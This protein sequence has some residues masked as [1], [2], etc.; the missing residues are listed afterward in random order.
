MADGSPPLAR[1]RA[2]AHALALA[3]LLFLAPL[4]AGDDA[5]LAVKVID[6]ESKAPIA[7]AR[8]FLLDAATGE[9]YA[10]FEDLTYAGARAPAPGDHLYVYARGYDV[11]KWT[12]PEKGAIPA[13][14]DLSMPPA[15]REFTI[16]IEGDDAGAVVYALDLHVAAPLK[17]PNR[18]D[19]EDYSMHECKGPVT[20]AIPR[21]GAV[22]ILPSC[23]EGLFTPTALYGR[24]GETVKLRLDRDRVLPLFCER[25]DLPFDVGRIEVFP[26]LLWTPRLPP[27]QID[28]WR[29]AI[30]R[31]G[32]VHGGLCERPPELRLRPVVPLHFFG[33]LP[34]GSVYRYLA[35]DAESLDLRGPRTPKKIT[36]RPTIAG[37]PL[38]PGTL[39]APG[40]LDSYAITTLETARSFLRGCCIVLGAPDE[41]WTGVG[42]PASEVLTAWHSSVGLVHMTW[43]ED[44]APSGVPYPGALEVSLAPHLDARGYVSVYAIWKGTGRVRTTPP[45]K[46]L[47]K[48]FAPGVREL[49]FPGLPPLPHAMEIQVDLTDASG[50]AVPERKGSREFEVTAAALVHRV[51]LGA[52]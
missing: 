44:E 17:W 4:S 10:S 6:E 27:E 41:P 31:P 20:M 37:R 22:L 30:N 9:Q 24:P 45:D 14:V 25:G 38:P 26:D 1:A 32:W 39:I 18:I 16:A 46:P 49:R 28:T 33:M 34:G 2:L 5:R 29:V 11:V 21:G 50:N 3:L 47:R 7:R 35:T 15:R 8:C 43:T 48:R 13:T 52:R 12:F 51:V 42:L 36:A 23:A 19:L 40:R